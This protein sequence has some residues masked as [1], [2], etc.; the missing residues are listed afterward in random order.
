MGRHVRVRHAAEPGTGASGFNA[1]LTHGGEWNPE[2]QAPYAQSEADQEP[3]SMPTLP[4]DI[5]D[6]RV[7][8]ALLI[9]ILTDQGVGTMVTRERSW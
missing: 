1:R 7:H 2:P 6:G 9:E 4:A 8:H 5:I 3:V